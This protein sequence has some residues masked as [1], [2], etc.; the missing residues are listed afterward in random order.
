MS[1][2]AT[3]LLITFEGGEG[4][5]KTTL[6]QKVF[7]AL[8]SQ[9]KEVIQ[10]RAPGGTLIGSSIRELLLRPREIPMSQ[11][12]ELFLFV[13]DRAQ[14]VDECIA[15]ALAEG[16]IVLCDRFNDSTFAYQSGARGFDPAWVKQ[17]CAFACRGIVPHLTF[18]LD[19]D[20]GLGLA[21]V[22]AQK[23]RIESEALEFHRTIRKTFLKI[24]QEEPERFILLDATQ[25]PDQVFQQAMEVISKLGAY[26]S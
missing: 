23:D 10:T 2:P 16:K 1:E 20:P 15:P 11:R 8:K 25:S 9:S 6:I 14:H 18:Y 26:E 22:Q 19:I 24:A 5:G 7:A 3:G 17:L 12:C 13:A 21:R 4:A